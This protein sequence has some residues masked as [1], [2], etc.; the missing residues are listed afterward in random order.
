M[1]ESNEVRTTCAQCRQPLTPGVERCENCGARVTPPAVDESLPRSPAAARALMFLSFAIVVG[2]VPLIPLMA[3][4]MAVFIILKLGSAVLTY[5][6]L[7][8][9]YRGLAET[10]DRT[11]GGRGQAAASVF[12]A[13]ILAAVLVMTVVGTLV[14]ELARV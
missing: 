7:K 12:F 11:V 5:F 3:G 14:A 1:S 13:W 8:N 9:G 6:A 10:A 2:F 4:G